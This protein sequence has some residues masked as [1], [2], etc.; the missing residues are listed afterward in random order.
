MTMTHELKPCPFC[1]VMPEMDKGIIHCHSCAS[2]VFADDWQDRPIED[3]LR[4]EIAD[5][6]EK[7]RLAHA[8][9]CLAA[10]RCAE[11]TDEIAALKAKYA[12]PLTDEREVYHDKALLRDALHH[13][14]LP[15]QLAMVAEEAAELAVAA[16]HMLRD[17]HPGKSGAPDDFCSEMADVE[18]M[19]DQMK[20]AG[21]ADKIA[22]FKA[23]KMLRLGTRLDAA[24]RAAREGAR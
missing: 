2:D 19:I 12:G 1:D 13:W 4:A 9:W 5:L 3:A 6:R 21:Y 17:Q 18:I 7:Y 24:I 22:E 23:S 14:G 15:S 10:D 8:D 16:M 20:V 11:Y